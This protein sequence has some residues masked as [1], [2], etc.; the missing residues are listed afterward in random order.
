MGNEAFLTL[1][2]AKSSLH[3]TNDRVTTESIPTKTRMTRS[4]Q[5]ASTRFFRHALPSATRCAEPEQSPQGKDQ[6]D[7]LHVSELATGGR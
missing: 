3:P 6:R 5:N 4:G 7:S 1:C 2:W